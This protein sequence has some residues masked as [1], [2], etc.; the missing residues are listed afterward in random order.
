MTE[1]ARLALAALL[2][3]SDRLEDQLA[4][5]RLQNDAELAR[6]GYVRSLRNPRGY[7]K[8]KTRPEA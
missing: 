4:W 6:L 7:Y 3:K 1:T 5:L 2:R 8:V